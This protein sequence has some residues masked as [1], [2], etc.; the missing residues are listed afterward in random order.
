MNDTFAL[1]LSVALILDTLANIGR[2][3]AVRITIKQQ[4]EMMRQQEEESG[5]RISEAASIVA[6]VVKTTID[7][8][9]K[10]KDK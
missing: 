8:L 6:D 4:D 1:I 9:E 5:K 2:L 10:A 3:V 7:E